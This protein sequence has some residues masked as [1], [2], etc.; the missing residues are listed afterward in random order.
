MVNR[1]L[2]HSGICV[3][4]RAEF[5]GKRLIGLILKRIG[6]DRINRESI[7][8][9]L[10]FQRRRIFRNIPGNMQRNGVRG[11]IELV[12]QTNIFYFFLQAAR[13]A[14]ARKTP[15]TR[16]ACAQRPGW[17]GNLEGLYFFDHI[18]HIDAFLG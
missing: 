7:G 16:T 5:I 14:A 9:Q 6:I 17:N 12:Q 10:A 2:T 11:V 15:E 1:L 18:L 13:F 4:K 3:A 8:L